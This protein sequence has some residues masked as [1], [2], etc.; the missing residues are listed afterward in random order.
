MRKNIV[1][2]DSKNG[3]YKNKDVCANEQASWAVG[4]Q[5]THRPQSKDNIQMFQRMEIRMW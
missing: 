2:S 3:V 4:K 1:E 5:I